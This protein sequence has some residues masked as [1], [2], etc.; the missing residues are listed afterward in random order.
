MSIDNNDG[1]GLDAGRELF[2]F[3]AIVASS[4]ASRAGTR[5]RPFQAHN[6]SIAALSVGF[7]ASFGPV[8]AAFAPAARFD[9]GNM[10]WLASGSTDG[11]AHLLRTA[12]CHT[13]NTIHQRQCGREERDRQRLH[14]RRIGCRVGHSSPRRQ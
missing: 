2:D 10:R 13:D 5:M 11:L 14:Q 9:R 8:R 12:D 4:F 3:S 7:S 1:V 6:V